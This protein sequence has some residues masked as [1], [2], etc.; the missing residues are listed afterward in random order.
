MNVTRILGCVGGQNAFAFYFLEI[1][2]VRVGQ[3]NKKKIT[4]VGSCIRARARAIFNYLI[5]AD[6]EQ[7]NAQSDIALA[8]AC[9]QRSKTTANTRAHAKSSARKISDNANLQIESIFCFLI[10]FKHYKRIKYQF[11]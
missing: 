1:A 6:D 5:M 7:P 11:F 10:S 4:T 8:R 2:S 9:A 3:S